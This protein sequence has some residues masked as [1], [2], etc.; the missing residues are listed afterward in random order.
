MSDMYKG[1]VVAFEK[2]LGEERLE[3]IVHAIR[4]IKGVAAIAAQPEV[5]DDFINRAQIKHELQR[6]LL[7][8]I[9]KFF[10]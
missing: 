8:A 3:N 4:M 5:R 7:E 10:D 2:D 1:V 9:D 6:K